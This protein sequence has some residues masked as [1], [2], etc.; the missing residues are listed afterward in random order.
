MS[1]YIIS[2]R[3]ISVIHQFIVNLLVQISTAEDR[4]P[5]SSVSFTFDGNDILLKEKPK[6][7][8][9]KEAE[10]PPA[11]EKTG[12]WWLKK[13]T[14]QVDSEHQI[15]DQTRKAETAAP[16]PDVSSA[17]QDFIE[18]EKMCKVSV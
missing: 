11:E 10:P 1:T 6:S 17:T 14:T 16:S 13:A 15:K 18:K 2:L 9:E 12:L 3:K 8:P 5:G 4:T 7:K